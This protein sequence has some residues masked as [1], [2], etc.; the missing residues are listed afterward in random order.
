[1]ASLQTR[2]ASLAAQDRVSARSHSGVSRL[3]RDAAVRSAGAREQIPLA[4][5]QCQ[6]RGFEAAGARDGK[7]ASKAITWTGSTA[8]RRVGLITVGGSH[9]RYTLDDA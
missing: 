8:A 7:K 2:V 1:V 9:W 5:V 6:K 4:N 3:R